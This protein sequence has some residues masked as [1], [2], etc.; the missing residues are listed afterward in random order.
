MGDLTGALRAYALHALGLGLSVLPPNEDG[1]KSPLADCRDE[2][3]R[4]TWKPYQ[5]VRASEQQ[6]RDWYANGRTGFGFVTGHVSGE[7][8]CLDFDDAETYTAFIAACDATGL[9]DLAARIRAGYESRT[10]GGAAHWPYRCAAIGSNVKL[11]RRPRRP[12]EMRG[13]GDTVKTLIEVKGEGGYIV[14]APSHGRVHPSGRPYELVS[15]S[16]ETIET[17]TIEERE[18]LHRLARTFDQMPVRE[19]PARGEPRP[20]AAGGRPGDDFNARADWRD[21]LEPHGWRFVFARRDGVEHWR[22]PGKDAGWSATI[23]HAG[24]GLLYVFS[25]STVFEA[26]RGYS[27]FSAY[28]LLNHAG[29]FTAAARDLAGRG[30]GQQLA[31]APA[32]DSNPCGDRVTQL[33]QRIAQLERRCERYRRFAVARGDELRTEREKNRAAMGL[34]GNRR[35]SA[36]QRLTGIGLAYH[37]SGDQSRGDVDA[38][39]R[40]HISSTQIAELTGQSAASVRDHIK[41]FAAVGACTRRVTR[42][43]DPET[44]EWRSELRA[45][46]ADGGATVA[47]RLQRFA[48]LDLERKRKPGTGHPRPVCPEHPD[49]PVLV[50]KTRTCTVCELVI[51]TAETIEQPL[52]GNFS[53]SDG[54]EEDAPPNGDTRTHT[55]NFSTSA[56]PATVTPLPN[57]RECPDCGGALRWL[58]AGRWVCQECG[59]ETGYLVAAELAA[60]GRNR[61]ATLF[62]SARESWNTPP[63]II[64]AA[65]AALGGTIDLDPCSDDAEHPNV[66]AQQHYT[67][68]DDGLSREWHGMVYLNP[69]YGRSISAWTE[70]LLAEYAAGRVV[71]AV[72]LLPV[73][74]GTRWFAPLAR[75]PACFIRGRLRFS[76]S[77]NTAPFDSVLVYLG[78]DHERFR[79]ATAELGHD[80]P[81]ALPALA[82]A[83]GG[84]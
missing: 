52:N 78:P 84:D 27:A 49:A 76:G 64:A 63:H 79:Q 74:T 4:A 24:S 18:Q 3:G 73:R 20:E 48:A 43:V 8:E 15:G 22:R 29:D 57:S 33:E 17:I 66:P 83:A 51:D 12:E 23:N 46:F 7:L 35:L 10:P 55:R 53:H 34:L 81:G 14:D 45:G 19:Q 42:T 60:A 70:K 6:V 38:A 11:A 2:H 9:G 28:A 75:F 13:P 21:V 37:V 1:T 61:L 77:R 31:R 26:E 72:A 36:G 68:A 62:S 41:T 56:A 47:D 54:E 5:T 44:G 39:D 65:E 25:T 50:R 32:P 67:A 30:Y 16:L 82:G 80:S 69:P 58:D 40:A 71:A 59:S